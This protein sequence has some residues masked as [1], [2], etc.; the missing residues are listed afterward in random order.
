MRT[1]NAVELHWVHKLANAL[2]DRLTNEEVEKERPELY[3][4]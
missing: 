2:A 4:T 1:L 3:D